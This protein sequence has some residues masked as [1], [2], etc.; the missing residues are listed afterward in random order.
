MRKRQGGKLRLF[1]MALTI[2]LLFSVVLPCIPFNSL[3][4]AIAEDAGETV[5][6]YVAP[7]LPS[8][9]DP[10]DPEHPEE[11]SEEQLYA[12]SAILIEAT[13]G[14]V[15]FEKNA[16]NAMYPAST[17]KILTTLLGIMMG[18]LNQQVTMSESAHTVE[19]GSA[20]TGLEVGETI[21][22]LDLLYATM[23]KSGNDGANLIAETISGS[24]E[25][26]AELMN[27]AAAMYGCT[28]THFSNPSGLF[29]ENHYTTARDMAKI[30]QAAMENETFRK[31]AGTFSYSLPRSNLRRATV[32]MG[33]SSNWMN[34]SQE[35]TEKSPSTYYPYAIGIKT[36]F[37]DRAGYCYVGAAEKDGVELISVVLYTSKDGRWLDSKKLMEYGF[38]QFVSMT[39]DELY[40]ENPIVLETSGFSLDDADMGRLT[41]N[42]VPADGARTVHIV[43]T[44]A[45][46]EAM[47]RNLRQ[48]MLVEYSRDFSAP[49]QKGEVMGTMTYFPADGGSA[50]VYNLE[51]GRTIER[52]ENAPLTLD[53]IEAAVQAD[54]NPL[55]PL[56]VEM[57]LMV[58]LPIGAVFL[59]IR[60]LMRLFRR[61]GRHKKGRVPKP[62]NRF[63]R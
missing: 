61:T 25:G 57:V 41:L 34:Q 52:R 49:I 62:K 13:T 9:A 23:I 56:S 63:F 44:K 10:Y 30:A 33:T 53:E 50:V 37:I 36:G 28:N 58:V 38:S 1:C 55:P 22:F 19:A 48:T 5:T 39:P 35:D 31:I 29:D 60:L 43:A 12:K 14:E 15:I 4:T 32:V 17:T 27:Q 45:E 3:P 7:K 18:D 2:A 20:T 16:D 42:A 6:T 21:N 51:A 8:D 24:Y 59:V 47:A 40:S 54:P 26:F 46:L 11:L